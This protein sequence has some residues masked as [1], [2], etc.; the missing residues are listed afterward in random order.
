HCQDPPTSSSQQVLRTTLWEVAIKTS[1]GKLTLDRDLSSTYRMIHAAGFL[2]LPFR[3]EHFLEVSTLPM[4]HRDPFDRMLIAQAR[5][6]NLWLLTSDPHFGN[7]DVQ[8]I[9]MGQA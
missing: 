3:E 9:G 2:P 6:E 4:H 5:C 7:Y 1:I 8:L